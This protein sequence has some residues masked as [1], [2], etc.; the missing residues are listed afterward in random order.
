MTP[1]TLPKTTA[2][3]ATHAIAPEDLRPGD[4]LAVTHATY[5][6]LPEGPAGWCAKLTPQTIRLI[7]CEAGEAHR[8]LAVC[9]PFVLT[10]A[11]SGIDRTLDLRRHEVRR[12][13]KAFGK[14]AFRTQDKQAE[15][16]K[17]KKAGKAKTKRGKRKGK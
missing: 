8:V 3:A 15:T 7:P 1:K 12:L 4:Y 6:L 11:A 17:P 13:D 14:Q 16:D 10:C 2:P 5:E 9:L